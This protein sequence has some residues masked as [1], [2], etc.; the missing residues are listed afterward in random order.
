MTRVTRLRHAATRFF[1][2]PKGL[3][4]LLLGALLIVAAFGEDL[5]HLWAGLATA[6]AA[7]ALV[8]VALLRWRKGKWEFPSG[9]VL[10]GMLVGMVMS[11]HEPWRVGAIVSAV[12]V[13]LKYVVRTRSANVFNPAALALVGAYYV[14]GAGHSWWGALP[15]LSLGIS[16]PALLLTGIFI[17]DRVNKLPLA[18]AFLGVY[19]GL[20]TLTSFIVDPARVAEAFITP[21]LQAALFFAFFILTDPPTS[22]TRHRDQLVCGAVVA[23]ASFATFELLGVV[24]FLLAGVLVGNVQEAWRRSMQGRRPHVA[25]A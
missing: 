15:D 4:I 11:P 2:T 23:I 22:P 20:F 16:I 5:R 9:A 19:Y 14:F 24:Y 17:A 25:A 21:D 1:R 8:D 7:A 6:V 12:A 3:L 13:A 10:T 18:L